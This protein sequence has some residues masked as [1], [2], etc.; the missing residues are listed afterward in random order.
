[1]SETNEPMIT[2]PKCKAPIK[3]TETLAAPFIE[4]ARAE[5]AKEADR[6]ETDISA[7]EEALKE[8]ATKLEQDR[9]SVQMLVDEQVEQ[10]RKAL[11][12]SVRETIQRELG[13]EMSNLQEELDD[14]DKKLAAARKAE[15]D[16][17]KQQR[18]LED[19]RRELDLQKQR[20]LDEERDKIR[21]AT[22][23]EAQ[24]QGRLREKDKDKTIAD[25][26]IKVDEMKRKAE[27]GSQQAQG[28]VMEIEL[29]QMLCRSFPDDVIE[30]VPKGVRGGDVIQRVHSSSRNACGCILWES[31]RTR[32]WSNGW[33]AKLRQDQ[34]DV[35]ASVSILVTQTMPPGVDGFALIEGIWVTSWS[36]AAGL[37]AALRQGLVEVAS[38]RRSL[39]GQQSKTEQVYKYL[40]SPVFRNRVQGMVEAVLT[41]QQDLAKEKR[42]YQAQWAK[43][44]KQLEQVILGTAGMYGD[45]QGIIGA[46]LPEIDG[47]EMAVIDN[48][49][50]TGLL[51]A[52]Q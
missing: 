35:K 41:M 25:L 13:A 15:L 4:A 51:G 50:T 1:M 23:K 31:K 3:L 7:R 39:E 46:T 17:R 5:F 33:L 18:E 32:N 38:A 22:L 8:Q 20:E 30:E 6:R 12:V 19:Q 2:C 43:R 27:Q 16:I 44:E 40:A 47:M 34:R 52:D 28:E 36:C 29:E 37:A 14:K 9:K 42:A 10:Q 11:T 48:G 24:E 49:D 45:F 21:Q 26:L